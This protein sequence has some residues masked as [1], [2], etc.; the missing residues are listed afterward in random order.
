MNE[1]IANKLNNSDILI[2]LNLKEGK[3]FTSRMVVY[4]KENSDFHR[5]GLMQGITLE[6]SSEDPYVKL[7]VEFSEE[8]PEMSEIL[9]KG[10]KKNSSLLSKKGCLIKTKK[11]TDS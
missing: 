8:N 7:C 2:G 4:A 1:D 3:L 11:W 5:I 10:L 6:A 9:K